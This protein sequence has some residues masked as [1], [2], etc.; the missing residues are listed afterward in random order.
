MQKKNTLAKKKIPAALYKK[1]LETMPVCCVDI[2][3][4]SG[5]KVFLFKRAY[6]PE[7][8]EWWVIGGRVL[9]GETLK[10]AVIRKVKEEVGVKA[11]ISKM[12]GVYEYFSKVNRF[13]SGRKG[14]G[15]HNIIICFEAEPIAKNFKFKLNEEYKGYKAI[16][17]VY[18]G[19]HPYVKKMLKDSG[20]RL[21]T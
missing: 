12:V 7:K 18:T 21:I 9:R 6:E 8:D 15:T 17:G 4:R 14:K 20:F 3:F 13:D 19:L 2:V 5:R 10:E 11:K 16:K 1:F